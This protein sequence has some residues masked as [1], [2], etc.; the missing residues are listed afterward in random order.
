MDRRINT[1]HQWCVIGGDC[2]R[3]LLV[4]LGLWLAKMFRTVSYP[5]T[6]AWINQHTESNVRATVLSIHGQA[7][8]FDQIAGSPVVGF[9]GTL[10]SVRVAISVSAL[11]LTLLM[12][13]FNRTLKKES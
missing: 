1:I 10:S 12:L 8:A 5:L 13:V 3:F 11:M 6:E 9:I 7:D 4:L 2:G